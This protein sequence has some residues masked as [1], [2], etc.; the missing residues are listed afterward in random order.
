[1]SVKGAPPAPPPPAPSA[2]RLRIGLDI[3]VDMPEKLYVRGRGLDSEWHGNIEV[4]GTADD[5]LVV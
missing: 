2:P 1:M 4:T 3:K 5:P